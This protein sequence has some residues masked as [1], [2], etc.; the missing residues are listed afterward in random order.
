LQ[1]ETSA[2][3][4]S[5]RTLVLDDR[6]ISKA[7]TLQQTVRLVE[8]GFAANALGCAVSLPVVIQSLASFNV[9]FGIKS[10]YLKSCPST[11]AQSALIDYLSNAVGDVLGLKV[12]GY[13]PKNSAV[14]LPAHRATL[15]LLDPDTGNVV[16][17]MSANSITR[18][19]TAAAGAIAAKYLS[20]PNSQTVGILGAGEQAHAQL[21]ALRLC[22]RISCVYVWARRSAAAEAYAAAWKG[23][24]ID[25][26]PVRD[27]RAATEGVDIVV[28]T[29]PS[30]EALVGSDC[31][32]P[33]THI[34]AVGADGQGKQE[35]D[36]GLLQ[37]AKV[38]V[39]NTDQSLE[40][41]EL[42]HAARAGIDGKEMIYAELGEIC[43]QLK[44]GRENDEEITVFDSSGVSF[45]DLVVA[46]YLVR[47][48]ESEKFGKH[49]L[50]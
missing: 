34:T 31:V 39:D 24:G 28:T 4:N 9:H 48:A 44:P 50:L 2:F 42:Q 45:Q 47:Q 46:G 19:R 11:S 18:L 13:W 49:V 25:V 10:G 21:E 33:G 26:E 41:G 22:R 43:A 20:R 30:R 7:I 5:P 29:T 16:A 40:I 12:G 32:R 35:L 38:V 17:V 6:T 36:V 8:A 23:S 1:P 27:V 3:S 15:L 37:R 14:G